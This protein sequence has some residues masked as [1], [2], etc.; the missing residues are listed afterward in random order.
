MCI[1]YNYIMNYADS[2]ITYTQNL[3]LFSA[4]CGIIYHTTGTTHDD[5]SPGGP[6]REI[7]KHTEVTI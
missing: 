7:H 1:L 6:N 3:L 2:F 4:T 5:E